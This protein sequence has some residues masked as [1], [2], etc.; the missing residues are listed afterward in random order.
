M[1]PRSARALRSCGLCRSAR[2]RR[3]PRWKSATACATPRRN[4]K[5]YQSAI[6]YDSSRMT[7][8][9][10]GLPVSIQRMEKL[11]QLLFFF[12]AEDGIRDLT[13]TGV[14]TC[15]LPICISLDRPGPEES[16]PALRPGTCPEEIDR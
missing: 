16:R 9:A 7:A 14:Q 1:S 4:P 3:R 5:A 2:R 11:I 12:E 6:A 10:T 13:V 8:A 15:A